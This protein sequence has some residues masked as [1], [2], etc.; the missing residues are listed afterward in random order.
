MCRFGARG[1]KYLQR[2]GDQVTY[3]QTQSGSRGLE[4]QQ[5][6]EGLIKGLAYKALGFRTWRLLHNFAQRSCSDDDDD[7]EEDADDLEVWTVR[8]H[9]LQQEWA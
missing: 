8:W 7:D 2:Y 3:I 6:L 5:R 4:A 9:L 1:K